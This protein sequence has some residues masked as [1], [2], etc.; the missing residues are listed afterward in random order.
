MFQLLS[1]SDHLASEQQRHQQGR[2]RRPRRAKRNVLKNI[3][4]FYEIPLAILEV[5]ED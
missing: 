3:Q 1:A 5:A 4:T 2:D